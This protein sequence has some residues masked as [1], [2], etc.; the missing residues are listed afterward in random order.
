MHVLGWTE[1]FLDDPPG[2]GVR[3]NVY[4]VIHVYKGISGVRIEGPPP[5]VSSRRDSV[6]KS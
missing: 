1:V 4:I 3:G 6:Q 5:K 2:V